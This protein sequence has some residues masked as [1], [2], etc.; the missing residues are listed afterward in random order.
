M[1][2]ADARYGDWLAVHTDPSESGIEDRD[3]GSR[4][5]DRRPSPV[6]FDPRSSD[7][8]SSSSD[9]PYGPPHVLR[10]GEPELVTEITDAMLAAAAQDED[11]LRILREFGLRSYVCVPLATRGRTLGTMTFALSESGRPL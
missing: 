7:P 6:T 5:E 1:V 8:R 11:H 4:I 9:A 2:Q 10:T 3:R